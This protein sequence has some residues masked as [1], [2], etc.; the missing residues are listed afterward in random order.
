MT[1]AYASYE[2]G[3]RTLLE[4][5]GEEHPLYDDARVVQQQL[6]ENISATRHNDD[7]ATRLTERAEIV[8]RLNALTREALGESFDDLCDTEKETRSP[9]GPATYVDTGGGIYIKGNVTLHNSNFVGR[10]Q[11]GAAPVAVLPQAAAP[12]A[13]SW[14]TAPFEPETVRVPA[15]TFTMGDDS[16]A[17]A[18]PQHEV[19]LPAFR[20][21]RKPVT[22]Q[23]YHHYLR[24]THKSVPHALR[25]EKGTRPSPAQ[26]DMPVCGVT[27]HD[28][29]DYCE[30]LSEK[31][32]RRYILP[33]EAQ[34][35]RAVQEDVDPPPVWG[36]VREWTTTLWGERR[37]KPDPRYRYPWQSDDGRDDLTVN[38]Q[39][40]RV[41]RGSAHSHTQR[42]PEYP[43]SYGLPD[44]MI[45]FRV[46]IDLEE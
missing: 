13:P 41:T 24:D 3:V 22:N 43:G 12:A 17:H 7:T 46:V 25:W 16:V 30:W 6:A 37:R 4:R 34:W 23:E 28:A 35:E 11:M 9:A 1:D 20:I 14:E 32:N 18:S 21:G 5:L 27:W 19:T 40:R 33:S 29:L 36:D 45:G 15:G 39:V 38:D 31:T 2:M 10:D 44:D 42:T 8:S 26:Q